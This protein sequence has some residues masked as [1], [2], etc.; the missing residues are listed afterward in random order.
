[1]ASVLA[2]AMLRRFERTSGRKRRWA[3][4]KASRAVR[5]D[6]V[7]DAHPKMHPRDKSEQ[8]FMLINLAFLVDTITVFFGGMMMVFF[9]TEPLANPLQRITLNS[10][11]VGLLP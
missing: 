8:C 3:T 11:A 6:S 4:F 1:M 7:G 10:C 9:D 5:L 2:L